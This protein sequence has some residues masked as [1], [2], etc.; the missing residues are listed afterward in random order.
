MSLQ[1]PVPNLCFLYQMQHISEL[2]LSKA[3][4]DIHN[5]IIKGMSYVFAR[6]K[7]A[8]NI[9]WSAYSFFPPG[10]HLRSV[11]W[12]VGSAQYI[13]MWIDKNNPSSSFHKKKIIILSHLCRYIS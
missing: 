4:T 6:L 1:F 5:T 7:P 11:L 9:D 10:L 3:C 12:S 13:E 2:Y 8:G